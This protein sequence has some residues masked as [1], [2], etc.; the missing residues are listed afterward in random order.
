MDTSAAPTLS[1]IHTRELRKRGCSVT[2]GHF[3]WLNA[4][5][6]AY[7]IPL[8]GLLMAPI[9][10][11]LNSVVLSAMPK[12]AHAAMTGLILVFSALGGTLGSRITAIV[13]ARF[14]GIHAFYFSLIPMTLLLGTLFLF[15]RETTRAEARLALNP[16]LD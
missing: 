10:P 14:G 1:E 9:Y 5:L 15:R 6:A 16:A 11:V 13:F 7:L 2:G 4:P 3:T 8:I 12:S